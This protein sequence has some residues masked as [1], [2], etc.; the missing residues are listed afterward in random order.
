M[1]IKNYNPQHKVKS[2]HKTL[3]RAHLTRLMRH[4]SMLTVLV[5]LISLGGACTKPNKEDKRWKRAQA[6]S[7]RY[8]AKYTKLARFMKDDLKVAQQR[9]SAAIKAKPTEES[10][11]KRRT[12]IRR[13]L[14]FPNTLKRIERDIER[15]KKQNQK[16]SQLKSADHQTAVNRGREVLRQVTA[17]LHATP[18][19]SRQVVLAFLST[20]RSRI[21]SRIKR[22]QP[23]LSPSYKSAQ[24]KTKNKDVPQSKGLPLKPLKTDVVLRPTLKLETQAKTSSSAPKSAEI[25]LEAPQK[26]KQ[27][28][29]RI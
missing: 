18:Q 2:L 22:Q 19:V 21:V 6:T 26:N 20:Q 8:Q 4:V 17:Q 5:S 24:L 16:L 12:A 3:V 23:L 7:L 13:A 11:K 27:Q 25:N 9:W 28:Q 29:E 14:K 15:L 1:P 10:L